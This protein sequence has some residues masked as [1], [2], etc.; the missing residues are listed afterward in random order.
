LGRFPHRVPV[1]PYKGTDDARK[2]AQGGAKLKSITIL[3]TPTAFFQI[4]GSGELNDEHRK[5]QTG[6]RIETAR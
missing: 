3:Q 1:S 4:A 2:Q 6:E 5:L